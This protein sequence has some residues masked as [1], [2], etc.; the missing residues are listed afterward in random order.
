MRQ[1]FFEICHGCAEQI[2]NEPYWIAKVGNRDNVKKV[3]FH[4]DC[5]AHYKTFHSDKLLWAEEKRK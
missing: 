3:Y 5:Y 4:P 1:V 2:R